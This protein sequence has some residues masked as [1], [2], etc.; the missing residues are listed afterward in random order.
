MLGLGSLRTSGLR[1]NGSRFQSRAC[2]S[3]Y[4]SS[5]FSN[6]FGG[7]AGSSGFAHSKSGMPESLLRPQNR[8]TSCSAY[9]LDPF[10]LNYVEARTNQVLGFDN[11]EG[12]SPIKEVFESG[13]LVF[14]DTQCR[15]RDGCEAC[16][17]DWVS[18]P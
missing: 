2:G 8:R 7:A 17:H 12:E 14:C 18:H 13:V 11:N 9:F 15:I 1:G 3:Q 4:T 6:S 10:S 16:T 5:F